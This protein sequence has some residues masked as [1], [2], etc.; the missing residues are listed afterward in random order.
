LKD[1]SAPFPASLLVANYFQFGL[2]GLTRML[3]LTL[4]AGT[5]SNK[6]FQGIATT[7]TA[8]LH[9]MNL[10]LTR[11]AAVLASPAISI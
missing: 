6:V 5:E 10:Q 2:P 11:A 7:R 1:F 3:K 4:A 8:K 9:V